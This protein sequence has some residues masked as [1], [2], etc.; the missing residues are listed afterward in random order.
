VKAIHPITNKELPVYFASYVFNEY[1]TGA[2]MGVPFHDE[3]DQMF[4]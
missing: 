2:V 1:G 3:R 4:A